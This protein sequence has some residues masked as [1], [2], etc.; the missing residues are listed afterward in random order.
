MK[1]NLLLIALLCTGC[2]RTDKQ[3]EM[4]YPNGQIK[5]LHYTSI[6]SWGTDSAFEKA[7]ISPDG[8]LTAE[9]YRKNEDSIDVVTPYGTVTS[10][11]KQPE[12][13]WLDGER[14]RVSDLILVDETKGE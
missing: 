3:D 2:Q 10:S 4:Y 13:I 7:T 9:G 12:Y 8:T 14:V 11:P 1:I 5:S 6:T